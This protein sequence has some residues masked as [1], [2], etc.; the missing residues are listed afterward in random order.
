[1]P[2]SLV[3]DTVLW[4]EAALCSEDGAG[5]GLGEVG[6][7]GERGQEEHMRA[8]PGSGA[9]HRQVPGMYMERVVSSGRAPRQQTCPGSEP[10]KGGAEESTQLSWN[11]PL[12]ACVNSRLP[13]P[14]RPILFDPTLTCVTPELALNPVTLTTTAPPPAIHRELSSLAI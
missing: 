5:R 8:Q 14:D 2:P 12:G 1:M 13:T 3:I 4:T 11:A 7:E 6:E 9:G 10:A